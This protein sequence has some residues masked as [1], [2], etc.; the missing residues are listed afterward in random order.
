MDGPIRRSSSTVD[1]HDIPVVATT[2]ADSF[3]NGI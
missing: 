1:I 2:Y 3:V